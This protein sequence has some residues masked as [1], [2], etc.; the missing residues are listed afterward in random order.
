MS[1]AAAPSLLRRSW[2]VANAN[3]GII[4]Q[5][6]LLTLLG[7]YAKLRAVSRSF[8]D[9]LTVTLYA[10]ALLLCA[11]GLVRGKAGEADS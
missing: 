6:N 7:R 11:W 4:G 8:S 3:E 2:Q 9:T 5:S 10:A 1:V